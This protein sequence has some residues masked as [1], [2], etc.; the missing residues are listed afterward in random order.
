MIARQTRIHALLLVFLFLLLLPLTV[1]AEDNKNG[2]HEEE[3]ALPENWKPYSL[4]CEEEDKEASLHMP[5]IYAERGDVDLLDAFIE[6]A[7]KNAPLFISVGSV[8]LYLTAKLVS[9]VADRGEPI[10]LYVEEISAEDEKT[11]GEGKTASDELPRDAIY[12]FDLGFAFSYQSVRIAVKHPTSNADSLHLISSNGNGTETVLKA[13]YS[14]S[15][16]SFFPEE[17]AFT[18]RITEEPLSKKESLIPLFFIVFLLF[19]IAGSVAL[20]VLIKTGKLK[21]IYLHRFEKHSPS[22]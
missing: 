16:A 1:C 22:K 14:D 12:R 17:T 15:L 9:D 6:V 13:A 10:L 2:E 8:K 5:A 4:L 3:E 19:L 11:D 21:R 7:K 20:L 18:L